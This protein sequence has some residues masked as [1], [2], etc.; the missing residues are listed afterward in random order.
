M[1]KAKSREYPFGWDDGDPIIVCHNELHREYVQK[2]FGM[3]AR[4]VLPS[5]AL[6]GLRTRKIIVFRPIGLSFTAEDNFR[7]WMNESLRCRLTPDGEL[8]LV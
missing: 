5:Q 7:R 2:A 8:F 3:K 1:G 4:Y 6:T